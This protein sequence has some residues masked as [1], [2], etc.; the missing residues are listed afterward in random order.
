MDRPEWEAYIGSMFSRIVT[1]LAILA[2]LAIAVVT[3]LTSAHA[4]RMSGGAN[5]AVH[6]IEMMQAHG[7][8]LHCVETEPCNSADVEICAFVCAGLSV[9]L[10][11]P[12]AD[13]GRDAAPDS[14]ELSY[15][16]ALMSR[17][18]SLSERPPKLRLL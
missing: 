12:I 6:A 5:G 8:T 9:Y 17:I 2:M 3:T 13:A 10:L 1:I 11:L 16:A 4:S 15:G 18:P 7:N 14:H